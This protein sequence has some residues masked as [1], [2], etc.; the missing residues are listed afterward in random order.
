MSVMKSQ[1]VTISNHKDDGP[2]SVK[3]PEE[4]RRI[5]RNHGFTNKSIDS[6]ETRV[7][8]EVMVDR[9]LIPFMSPAEGAK[10]M[11]NFTISLQGTLGKLSELI[12]EFDY[13][14]GVGGHDCTHDLIFEESKKAF[15]KAMQDFSNNVNRVTGYRIK[16]LPRGRGRSRP[17]CLVFVIVDEMRRCNI[18][19]KRT[20]NVQEV[21][22]L[23][24]GVLGYE[25]RSTLI[26]KKVWGDVEHLYQ[27]YTKLNLQ[28]SSQYFES[29][30]KL[31]FP[32]H[33]I[34]F[35]VQ[36]ANG[37]PTQDIDVEAFVKYALG[38]C[39]TVGSK[40]ENH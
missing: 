10:G 12:T 20:E 40:E 35:D 2:Y 34:S 15:L 6:L 24:Y 28:N 17:G 1:E 22:G 3:F 39:A 33:K 16:N 13:W 36:K 32:N 37:Q 21:L 30:C 31:M 19:P 23:I 9:L 5:L 25:E 29:A 27:L 8:W 26:S 18:N 7:G 4:T 38:Q 11:K 14:M